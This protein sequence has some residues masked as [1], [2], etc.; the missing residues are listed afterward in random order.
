MNLKPILDPSTNAGTARW[1]ALAVAV[2]DAIRHGVTLANGAV[3]LTL[4]G[5]EI[6]ARFFG[7]EAPPPPSE[8]A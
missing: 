5:V 3:L 2:Y 1:A 4:A 7:T 6:A 8:A